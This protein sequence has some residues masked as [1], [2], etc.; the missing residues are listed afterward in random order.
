M[1][2]ICQTIAYHFLVKIKKR[3]VSVNVDHNTGEII[4]QIFQLIMTVIHQWNFD[5][6]KVPNWW[7]KLYPK[8]KIIRLVSKTYIFMKQQSSKEQ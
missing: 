4:L 5:G 3:Y 8:R 6:D 7:S 2:E 1:R